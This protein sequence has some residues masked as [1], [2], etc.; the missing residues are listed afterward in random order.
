[1]T[2][3]DHTLPV[4]PHNE[5]TFYLNRTNPT[6]TRTHFEHPVSVVP[7]HTPLLQACWGLFAFRHSEG[8]PAAS[9]GSTPA[10]ISPSTIAPS[11]PIPSTTVP[12]MD[13]PLRRR[14]LSQPSTST[15]SPPDIIAHPDTT[16]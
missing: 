6:H 3:Q 7:D 2:S 9:L 8:N 5:V 13:P 11:D 12:T 16:M 10:V 4:A 14:W 15:S 1:M